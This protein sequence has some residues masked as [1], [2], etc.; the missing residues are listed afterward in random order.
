MRCPELTAPVAQGRA[1]GAAQAR[2]AEVGPH[3]SVWR[4]G[5]RPG[6]QASRA[7]VGRRASQ[8]VGPRASKE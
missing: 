6:A 4:D 3:A 1:A 5:E 7:G 8:W 2:R